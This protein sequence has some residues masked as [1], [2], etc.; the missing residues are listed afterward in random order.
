M[1]QEFSS[2]SGEVPWTDGKISDGLDALAAPPRVLT[3]QRDLSS[4]GIISF[5]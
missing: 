3:A 2:P 1:S 5:F 4:L